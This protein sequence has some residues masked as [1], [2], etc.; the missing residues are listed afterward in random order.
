MFCPNCGERMDD[1][2]V[3]CGNCGNSLENNEKQHNRYIEQSV[4][5]KNTTV[6]KNEQQST[7]MHHQPVQS[8]Q[9]VNQ[10]QEQAFNDNLSNQKHGKKKKKGK[11]IAIIILI[12]ILGS[13]GG[14]AYWFLTSPVFEMKKL[15]EKEKYQDLVDLYNDDIEGEVIQEDVANILLNKLILE[16]IDEYYLEE[17]DSSYEEIFDMLTIFIELDNKE[18]STVASNSLADVIAT[19]ESKLIV[20]E[21]EKEYES[22][23]YLRAI[24]KY[25]QISEES[26]DYE[27]VTEKIQ[28][29][30]DTYKISILEATITATTEEEYTTAISLLTT[31]LSVLTD[32]V[33]L[34]ERKSELELGYAEL[35]KSNALQQAS[36]LIK[37][38]DYESAL[39]LLNEKCSLL[40]DDTDLNNLLSSTKDSY[41]TYTTNEVNGLVEE[42]KYD[43]AITMIENAISIVPNDSLNTLKEDILDMKPVELSSLTIAEQEKVTQVTDMVVTKDTVGNTY[44]PGN[45]FLFEGNNPYSSYES[46]FKVYL[47]KE[48]SKLV[49]E[50][51]VDE[52]GYSKAVEFN[53]FGDETKLIYNKDNITRTYAP[54]IVE[55][56]VS[57]V[58]WLYI[59]RPKGTSGCITLIL[60][61]PVLYK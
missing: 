57:D 44:A 15:L 13:I 46:Y 12:I 55:V 11:M 48:Y 4:Q 60:S 42:S 8:E 14:V 22:G 47:G 32:D 37:N 19:Y 3:F 18:L 35:A 50:L 20:A 17:D 52:A 36:E 33:D 30:K 59:S 21:A 54:E 25:E 24:E 39:D 38:N 6:P 7:G 45:L 9:F 49:F 28:E 16:K 43:E 23:D 53:I 2:S 56:N 34:L 58:E 41:I 10:K 1:D 31:A 26:N 27:F 29:A 61:N 51:A 40:P 5:Y